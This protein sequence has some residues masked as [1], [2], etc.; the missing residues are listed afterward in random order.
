MSYRD[1]AQHF[2]DLITRKNYS[3]AWKLLAEEAQTSITPEVIQAAVARMSAYV[4]GPIQEAEVMEDFILEEWPDK[5]P[6]DLAVVY[7]ALTGSN[8]SEAVT[9]T[10]AQYGKDALIRHLEWGRP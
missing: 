5:R 3:A 1:V 8:F 7:V 2:G 4:P 6:G 10:L 9:L